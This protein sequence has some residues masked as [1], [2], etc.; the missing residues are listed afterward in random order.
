MFFEISQNSQ[1]NTCASL[2]FFFLRP[3]TLLK[4]RFRHRCFP[5]NF[6]KFLRTSFLQNTSWRLFPTWWQG[7]ILIILMFSLTSRSSLSLSNVGD[8]SFVVCFSFSINSNLLELRDFYD[9]SISQHLLN[10]VYVG[11]TGEFSVCFFLGSF[12]GFFWISNFVLRL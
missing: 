10:S 11:N 8:L 7:L 5:V 6:V 9:I 4:S 12:V 3:A 1:E 2:F